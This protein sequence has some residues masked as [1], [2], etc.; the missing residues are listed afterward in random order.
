MITN[1]FSIFDPSTSYISFRWITII[2]LLLGLPSPI[3]IITS[4]FN[5]FKIF[6]KT[7][8][9]SEISP[10]LGFQSSFI[11]IIFITIFIFLILRN[12]FGLIPYVFS[13]TRHILISLRLSLPLWLICILYGWVKNYNNIFSHLVPN[14]TPNLLIIF[15]V[16]IE[17][18]SSTIRP[19]TLAVRLI[20]NITAGHLILSLISSTI[21]ILSIISITLIP[22]QILLFILETAVA[23][24]QAYVFTILSILYLSESK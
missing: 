23:F 4:P 7:Y 18:I 14:G 24:I 15:I 22:A 1:L 5:K 3:W 2:I 8:L 21:P 20:A 11:S 9:K 17:T 6:I 13:S 16:L 19:I 12:F 10:I